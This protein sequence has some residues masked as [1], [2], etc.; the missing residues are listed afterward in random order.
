MVKRKL[1]WNNW[2]NE[3]IFHDPKCDSCG[4][5]HPSD[6]VAAATPSQEEARLAKI[7]REFANHDCAKYPEP[8][9]LPQAGP[10][11]MLTTREATEFLGVAAQTLAKWRHQKRGPKYYKYPGDLGLVRYRL[12]DLQKFLDAGA[13]EP[14]TRR[15]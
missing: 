2:S 15:R 1:I 11:R 12:E 7:K 5:V 14:K 9:I 6:Y 8:R 10:K 3:A 13:V 4:W